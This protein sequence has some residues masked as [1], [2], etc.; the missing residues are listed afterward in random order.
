MSVRRGVYSQKDLILIA[1]YWSG[2]PIPRS[3]KIHTRQRPWCAGRDLSLMNDPASQKLVYLL[4]GDHHFIITNFPTR[5]SP[6]FLSST[7]KRYTPD[8][9][10]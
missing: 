4:S 10:A 1:N 5:V 3:R 7:V 6:V 2:V 9:T 8:T